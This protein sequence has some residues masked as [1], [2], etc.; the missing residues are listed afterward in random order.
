[1]RVSSCPEEHRL[2][3]VQETL[4]K[5]PTANMDNLTYLVRFLARLTKHEENKMNSSNIAIVIAPNLLWNVDKEQNIQMSN[6]TTLNLI[7]EMFVNKVDELFPEDLGPYITLT[8]D[9]LLTEEEFHRPH[10]KNVRLSHDPEMDHD[11]AESPKPQSRRKAKPAPTPPTSALHKTETELSISTENDSA[12][13]LLPP[14]PPSAPCPPLE[15]LSRAQKVRDWKAKTSTDESAV[16]AASQKRRSLVLDTD[17][18]PKTALV[19]LD[20]KP[21]DH[22]Y[23]EKINVL[24]MCIF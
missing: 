22:R 20:D 1:M 9:I 16:M 18:T 23:V 8:K 19:N 12:T 14:P 5:L 7:V 10:L 15:T 2:R 13:P 3:L 4:R 17:S 11:V 21:A 24:L 6:C